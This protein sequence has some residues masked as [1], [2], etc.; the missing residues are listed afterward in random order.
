MANPIPSSGPS[1]LTGDLV[2]DATTLGFKWTLGPDRAIDWSISG[3]FAGE[4]WAST[5]QLRLGLQAAFEAISYF[6]DVRFNFVGVF[7]DPGAAARAGSEINV[8]LSRESRLV[9]DDTDFW[10]F[11][12]FPTTQ[13]DLGRYDGA[14][15]DVVLNANSGASALTNFLPGSDGFLL[16]LHELGRGLISSE[17]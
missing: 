6:V 4:T 10:A 8:G 12:Y 2:I 16:M 7:G 11:G 14:H 5:E 17:P 3:G 15:G 13:Y 1:P 9:G